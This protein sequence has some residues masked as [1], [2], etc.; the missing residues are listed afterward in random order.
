MYKLTRAS[1]ATFFLCVSLLLPIFSQAQTTTIFP[2][3]DGESLR[4]SAN[5]E[6]GEA[7]ISGICILANSG[8]TVNGS[9]FNEFGITMVGFS[10]DCVREKVKIKDAASK[11]RK[12]YVKRVLRNDLR[13]LMQALQKGETMFSDTKH[14]I[15][16]TLLPIKA[17]NG[18]ENETSEQSL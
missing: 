9:L 5:I 14:G 7:G 8:G 17:G 13:C 6:M 10:Y 11:F 12:W 15:T 16:I 4:Y 2:V 3:N 18:Q 1:A